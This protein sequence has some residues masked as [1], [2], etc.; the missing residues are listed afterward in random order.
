[1]SRKKIPEVLEET[2]NGESV[3]HLGVKKMDK[4]RETFVSGFPSF[5]LKISG[6]GVA[7]V[8][9]V[10]A[11]K[12]LEHVLEGR[13]RNAIHF[14]KQRDNRYIPVVMDYFSKCKCFRHSQPG[15][16]NR[17]KSADRQ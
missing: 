4:I 17:G 2:H 15:S 12:D 13:R 1:M 6:I 11:I 8:I 16:G 5:S 10:P 7:G 3:A 14:P 9:S